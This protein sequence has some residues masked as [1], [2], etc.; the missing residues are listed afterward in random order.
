VNVRTELGE[1]D[2]CQ[3]SDEIDMRVSRRSKRNESNRACV[4]TWVVCVTLLC[5]LLHTS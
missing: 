4:W 5:N 1:S 2:I 3:Q